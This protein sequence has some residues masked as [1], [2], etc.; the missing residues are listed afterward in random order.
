[1]QELAE[2]EI[3]LDVCPTSNVLTGV[4][5]SLEEHPLPRLL[6]AGIHCSISTDDPAFFKTDLT[7]EHDA[8]WSLGL[9][10]REAF[11]AGLAGALCD[12]D[13]RDR[14]RAAGEAFDWDSL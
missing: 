12:E 11:A 7:R 6:A 13:T 10:P 14:L 5:G 1:M 8:A 3:V 2:R 4:I 9:H